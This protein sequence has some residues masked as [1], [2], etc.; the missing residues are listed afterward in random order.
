MFI[1]LRFARGSEVT[2]FRGLKTA[3]LCIYTS[4][5]CAR[6]RSD[7][8]LRFQNRPF[9]LRFARGSAATE[10]SGL[11]TVHLSVYT[12]EVRARER[13][14][15]VPRSQNRPLICI[16]RV[17]LDQNSGPFAPLREPL[18]NHGFHKKSDAFASE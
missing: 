11:K 13:S 17:V 14:D 2:Q 5:I 12:S 16:Y 9:R 1:R 18:Q 15:R 7:R 10:F 3:H 6:E 8:V 4:E